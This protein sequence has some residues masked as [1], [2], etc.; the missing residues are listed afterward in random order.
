[1]QA[2]DA[3]ANKFI[4]GLFEVLME[5]LYT[6]NALQAAAPASTDTLK[7]IADRRQVVAGNFAPGLEALTQQDFPSKTALLA[8]LKGTLEKANQFRQQADTAIKQPR[9]QRDESLRK[10]FIPVISDSVGAAVRVWFVALH[11]SAK[12]DPI[13]ARLATVKEIG[14]RMRDIAG[15]ERSNVGQAISAGEPIGAER[16]AANAAIRSRV[17]LLWLQLQNLTADPA[18]HP[19]IKHAMAEAQRDYFD[20][21]R[22]LADDMKKASD[23]GAKYPIDAAKW[24]DTTTPQLG[25]LLAVMYAGGKASEARTAELVSADLTRIAVAFG[26]LAIT[27]ATLAGGTFYVLRGVIRPLSALTSAIQ[28]LA[29]NDTAVEISGARR[30][31]EIG[32]MARAAQVFQANL[33]ETERL[34]LEQA[35]VAKRTTE[36]RQAEMLQFATRF[37]DTVGGIIGGVSAASNE[38]Q[39]TAQALSATAEETTRQT[40]AASSSTEQASANVKT[41]AAAADELS[42]SIKEISRQVSSSARIAGEAVGE[43]DRTNAK[44]QALAQAASRIGDVV[45]LIHDIAGQ[46]NLLALN[47]TIEAA[48]AGDAGRG[49]AVVASEVKSLAHQT[50]KATEDITQQITAIQN[51]TGESVEAIGSIGRTIGEIS[52]IATAIAAAVE[53]QAASTQEIARNVQQ[54]SL[55]TAEVSSNIRG[56]MS[57]ASQTTVAATQVLASADDLSSQSTRLQAEL[58]SFLATIKA[59]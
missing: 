29:G 10:A 51:A 56:V 14:W 28:R 37:E 12:A 46:T 23:V 1:M 43:A 26:L 21:F 2:F 20:G 49:F 9:D 24:V 47:A 25:T 16:L 50:A 27:L 45:K 3:G 42:D 30:T 41:V 35:T 48:R 17:D 55:G 19:A 38:L 53:E 52:Q 31:D 40:G 58:H 39:S 57:A 4:A 34:R 15:L 8:D 13:L 5:R 6:N 7:Q 22:K 44:V 33:K 54:A 18:T 59:A 36:E 11:S 32:A